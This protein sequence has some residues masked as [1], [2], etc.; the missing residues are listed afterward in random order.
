MKMGSYDECFRIED[1]E[2][3]ESCIRWR[4][5]I[6]GACIHVDCPV[7]HN[8]FRPSHAATCKLI[9]EGS[10]GITSAD[11]ENLHS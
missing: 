4:R 2:L 5:G 10:G 9:P 3:R 1:G 11:V 8:P 7:C 6:W